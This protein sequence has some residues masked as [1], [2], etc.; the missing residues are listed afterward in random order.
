M[1]VGMQSLT[2]GVVNHEESI[3][4]RASGVCV[5]L[6][7]LAF[8]YGCSRQS[9]EE[10]WTSATEAEQEARSVLDTARTSQ[11]RH[12]VLAPALKLYGEIIDDHPDSPQAEQALIRRAAIRANDTR[13]IELAIADYRLY[14]ERYPGGARAPLAMFLVGYMYNNELHNL[15]SAA[16]A[17]KRFLEKFPDDEMAS[18]ARFELN[19]LGKTPEELI[20][21]EPPEAGAASR[22]KVVKKD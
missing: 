5:L 18:S 2:A 9:P 8:M 17:Y 13:E 6:A 16:A 22:D 1:E 10:L 14:G 20:P 21:N 11:D 3:P 15:D 19:T 7:A 12:K 4:M